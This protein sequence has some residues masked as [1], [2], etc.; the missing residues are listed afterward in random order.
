MEEEVET[1]PSM[2]SVGEQQVRRMQEAAGLPD[3]ELREWNG[4]ESKSVADAGEQQIRRT[5]E[6][7]GSPDDE[8]QERDGNE[9]IA[10]HRRVR[11]VKKPQRYLNLLTD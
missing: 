6:A 4:I 8:L 10:K 7:V 5:Q 11:V 3:E 2:V 1:E 9:S